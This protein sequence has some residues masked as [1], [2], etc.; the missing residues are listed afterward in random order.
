MDIKKLKE[1]GV[2]RKNGQLSFSLLWIS[3]IGIAFC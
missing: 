2:I 1:K 3:I